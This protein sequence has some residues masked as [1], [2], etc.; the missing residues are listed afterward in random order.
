MWEALE[1]MARVLFVTLAAILFIQATV[2]LSPR[3]FERGM[4]RTRT[5][6]GV[7]LIVSKIHQEWTEDGIRR[8]FRVVL[9]ELEA[10]EVPAAEEIQP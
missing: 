6:A 10:A 2:Y 1:R 8:V 5:G 7:A 3:T 4:M 9:P